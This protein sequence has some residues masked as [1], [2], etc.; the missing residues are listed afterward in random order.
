MYPEGFG[1]EVRA[2]LPVSDI[3]AKINARL[4]FLELCT[5][6]LSLCRASQYRQWCIHL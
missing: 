3:S 2:C 4:N 5:L 6:C 1:L